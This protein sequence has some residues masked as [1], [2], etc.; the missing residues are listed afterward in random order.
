MQG[1][2]RGMSRRRSPHLWE[3]VFPASSQA[4]EETPEAPAGQRA[5][6]AAG[7]SRWTPRSESA[8]RTR[9]PPGRRAD[10]L[11]RS[12]GSASDGR[13]SELGRL[14]PRPAL[15]LQGERGLDVGAE[16]STLGRATAPA[17]HPRESRHDDLLPEQEVAHLQP[18][19]EA[20]AASAQSAAVRHPARGAQVVHH[21]GG[22]DSAPAVVT[23]PAGH[24]VVRGRGGREPARG[25]VAR[26]PLLVGEQGEAP[27]PRPLPGAH[28]EL[29]PP[30]RAVR[31]RHQPHG[32][33]GVHP[34]PPGLVAAEADPLGAPLP[35]RV[36][37]GPVPGVGRRL[38]QHHRGRLHRGQRVCQRR[39]W[40]EPEAASGLTGG[41]G[42]PGGCSSGASCDV[43]GLNRKPPGADGQH[44]GGAGHP[45]GCSSG[46]SCDV[47]GLNRKPPGADR[48]R[49][50]ELGIA[51]AVVSPVLRGWQSIHPSTQCGWLQRWGRVAG[52]LRSSV[53]RVSQRM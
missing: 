31:G 41:A 20:A 24:P 19:A 38:H 26:D 10:R 15:R 11:P 18:G 49:A 33:P 37:A 51:E 39:H 6:R 13:A 27:G 23:G 5:Q 8:V 45:G 44:V 14:L 3:W 30:R 35:V 50:E 17:L 2:G 34:R 46:A 53:L 4:F 52:S 32:E 12:P 42:H 48:R 1:A 36:G 28:E 29:R 40:A 9:R 22:A 43:T 16:L 25:A 21:T 7:S 47:T